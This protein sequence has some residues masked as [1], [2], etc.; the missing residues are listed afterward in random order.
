MGCAGSHHVLEDSEQTTRSHSAWTTGSSC[1]TGPIARELQQRRGDFASVQDVQVAL[2]G[3]G[4][5][6]ARLLFAVDLTKENGT[7][8]MRSFHGV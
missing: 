8:G 3:Q 4:V 6:P 5:G 2:R 7:A 1:G